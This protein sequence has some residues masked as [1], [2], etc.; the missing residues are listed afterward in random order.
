MSLCTMQNERW[1]REE[2]LGRKMTN[3]KYFDLTACTLREGPSRQNEEVI[4]MTLMH[5]ELSCFFFLCALY[6]VCFKNPWSSSS[7]FPKRISK[8]RFYLLRWQ[9]KDTVS[10]SLW[11]S[12][13]SKCCN[14]AVTGSKKAEQYIYF[15]IK[16][17]HIR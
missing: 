16:C 2:V 15:P 3:K 17:R 13:F 14:F 5:I 4:W 8:Y 6:P 7:P 12:I 10:T 9:K 1:S 11:V